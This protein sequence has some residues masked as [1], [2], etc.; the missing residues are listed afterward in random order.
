MNFEQKS[1]IINAGSE[2]RSLAVF[3][4]AAPAVYP[5]PDLGNPPRASGRAYNVMAAIF[6]IYSCI[7]LLIYFTAIRDSLY[8]IQDYS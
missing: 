4:L 8:S 7:S 3:S 5:R 1:D 2:T 6:L